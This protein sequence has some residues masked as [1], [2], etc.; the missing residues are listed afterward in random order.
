[1][2]RNLADT[3]L[4][5]A[6]YRHDL[7]EWRRGELEIGLREAARRSGINH[8]TIRDV[9][10]GRA[11]NKAVYPV[12]KALGLSWAMVHDFD[13][14]PDDFHLAVLNGNGKSDAAG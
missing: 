7:L 13:L 12:A 10:Q 5:P 2:A 14:Q 1:M 11:T 8:E 3:Q 9:F 4:F 6:H